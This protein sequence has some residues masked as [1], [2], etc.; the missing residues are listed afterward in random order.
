MKIWGIKIGM[1]LQKGV[2][3]HTMAVIMGCQHFKFPENIFVIDIFE[4]IFFS[5]HK[6]Q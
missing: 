6:I 3:T 2:Q 5:I 4:T 1:L